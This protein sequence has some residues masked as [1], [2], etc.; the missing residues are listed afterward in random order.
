[1][2]KKELICTKC[3]RQFNHRSNLSR[4]INHNKSTCKKVETLQEDN[5]ILRKY[6]LKCKELESQ[7][8]ELKN[9]IK[10][11]EDKI[12]EKHRNT[13][14]PDSP[15]QQSEPTKTEINYNIQNIQ[16]IQNV[17]KLTIKT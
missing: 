14:S 17:Q 11:D 3:N 6:E 5:D 16:N 2:S 1:M 12:T 7:I 15:I 10:Q 13:E 8:I 9:K 4:H